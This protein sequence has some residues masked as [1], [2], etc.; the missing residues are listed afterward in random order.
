MTN[1]IPLRPVNQPSPKAQPDA[2]SYSVQELA[3]FKT[4]TRETYRST[5]GVDAPAYD[6]GRV[7][8][9]WFDSTVDTSDPANVAVYKTLAKN[10]NGEWALRQL[11]L[12]AVEAAAVNLPGGISYPAYVVPPTGA[13][14]GGGSINPN[15][16][17]LESDARTL[18]HEVGGE[19]LMEDGISAVFPISYPPDEPRRM[20]AIVFSGKPVNVGMLLWT[21]NAKGVGSPGRWDASSGEP[22]WVADSP[23][24]AGLS[25]Q[26]PPREMPVRDLLPNEKLQTTLM[27]VSVIRTDLSAA[28]QPAGQFTSDDRAMLQQIHQLVTKLARSV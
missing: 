7:I 25:D 9:T 17:S 24:P 2:P 18:L 11:V 28:S 19:A 1:S 5:F 14:R 27:G 8:K 12:P 4:F 21:R 20:W 23:A 13:T 22:V 16:L 15:Y 3:L 10:S 26:R 6:P